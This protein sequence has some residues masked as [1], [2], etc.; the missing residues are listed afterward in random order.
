[1]TWSLS[2]VLTLHRTVQLKLNS[3]ESWTIK[4][5]QKQIR[6]NAKQN[7]I[8]WC[9]QC[10]K[11]G[12][13]DRIEGDLLRGEQIMQR[14]QL[15]SVPVTWNKSRQLNIQTKN[16]YKRNNA[17]IACQLHHQSRWQYNQNEVTQNSNFWYHD[18]EQATDKVWLS[19]TKW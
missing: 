4:L 13:I 12:A 1:M 14:T 16:T 15:P 6:E 10:N 8:R 7:S 11:P 19:W 2:S 18:S 5:N 9:E 17:N 3:D